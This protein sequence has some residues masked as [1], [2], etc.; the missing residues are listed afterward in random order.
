MTGKIIAWSVMTVACLFLVFSYGIG[1]FGFLFP[2]PMV[3][4]TAG[5]GLDNA[6]EMFSQRVHS[7]DPENVDNMRD[8]L[9]RSIAGEQHE[10]VVEW[11]QRYINHH[12]TN[13]KD[14]PQWAMQALIYS[15]LQLGWEINT[16][17]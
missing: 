2:A 1:L 8:A 14:I 15:G 3:G 16:G 17:G 6:A 12:Y 4:M 9:R 13:E 11:A 7:R 5:M 10:R